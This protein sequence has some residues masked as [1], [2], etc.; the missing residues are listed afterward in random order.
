MLYDTD[1]VEK[2]RKI[3]E[4]T[5]IDAQTSTQAL[6]IEEIKKELKPIESKSVGYL[7]HET[8][9]Y[10]VLGFLDFGDGLIKHHQV[11]PRTL[12]KHIKVIRYGI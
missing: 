6:F 11:I 5:W 7:L 8:K 3:V 12:I 1:F 10:I 4:V 9:D 2:P